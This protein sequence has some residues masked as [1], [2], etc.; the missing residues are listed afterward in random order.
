MIVD[1][2]EIFYYDESS[3]SC[4]KWNTNIYYK[5]QFNKAI[6]KPKVIKGDNAGTLK[7][8][9]ENR[10]A[11]KY[12]QKVYKV[13]RIIYEIMLGKIPEG[14]VIDHINGDSSDNRISNLRAVPAAVNGRNCAKAQNNKTGETGV[15]CIYVNGCSYYTATWADTQGKRR[16]KHFSVIKLGEELAFFLACE[17]REQQIN[18]LNLQGAGYTNR[19]GK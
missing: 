4:L 5:N 14:F 18:L 15:A 6:S 10:W 13:H 3:P 9:K 1:F 7:K 19:H 11:V 17:Y 2:R 12:D 8:S 16:C